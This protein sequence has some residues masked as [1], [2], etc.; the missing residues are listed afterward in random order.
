M[1]RHTI[2]K[3][4]LNH[5]KTKKNHVNKK[6]QLKSKKLIGG[7]DF[8]NDDIVY[9]I[10]DNTKTE[11]KIIEVL[12]NYVKILQQNHNNSLA[13]FKTIKKSKIQHA[14]PYNSGYN[15]LVEDSVASTE[16]GLTIFTHESSE[17][18]SN[19]KSA[20]NNSDIKLPSIL[21][22]FDYFCF[23][24]D[25]TIAHNEYGSGHLSLDPKAKQLNDEQLFKSFYDAI[26]LIKLIS[27]LRTNEK[28]IFI[29]SFGDPDVITVLLNRL[30]NYYYTGESNS[31]TYNIFETGVNVFGLLKAGHTD[32]TNNNT[33]S[34]RKRKVDIMQRIIEENRI[35]KIKKI[36]FFDDDYKNTRAMNESGISAIT[37]PGRKTNEIKL[38]PK[39]DFRRYGFGLDILNKLERD[40]E[41]RKLQPSQY[42]IK[43]N[44]LFESFDEYRSLTAFNKLKIAMRKKKKS[45]E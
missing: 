13:S 31:S 36:L 3:Q 26:N 7:V 43:E 38:V 20:N 21:D 25:D 37:I 9:I 41:E 42:M 23:D 8:K 27:Y 11:Y 19:N 24:F 29:I 6:R 12:P 40:I 34:I 5:N 18:S 15:N 2:K 30:I 35:G 10:D 4:K 17:S 39:K 22:K 1:K 44:Y 16:K 32:Q 45:V 33:A 14:N 28:K